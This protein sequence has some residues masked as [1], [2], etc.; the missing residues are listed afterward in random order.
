ME[1]TLID[2]STPEDSA[3]SSELTPS[4]QQQLEDPHHVLGGGADSELVHD[5]HHTLS[6]GVGDSQTLLDLEL[7]DPQ[8]VLQQQQQQ[9]LQQQQQQQQHQSKL[10]KHSDSHLFSGA[11]SGSSSPTTGKEGGGL[12][13]QSGGARS[14]AMMRGMGAT[15]TNQIKKG[16]RSRSPSTGPTPVNE[17]SI[18]FAATTSSAGGGSGGDVDFFASLK[19]G[20]SSSISSASTTPI[21][22]SRSAMPPPL[23]PSPSAVNT[24]F[25]PARTS[26]DPG[27]RR[28]D[29]PTIR[30]SAEYN[31]LWNSPGRRPSAAFVE[32]VS[33]SARSSV[34]GGGLGQ[35]QYQGGS[36][37]SLGFSSSSLSNVTSLNDSPYQPSASATSPGLGSGTFP[38]LNI[39]VSHLNS[40]V[41]QQQPQNSNNFADFSKFTPPPKQVPYGVSPQTATPPLPPPPVLADLDPLYQNLPTRSWTE[42]TMFHDLPPQDAIGDAINRMFPLTEGARPLRRLLRVDEAER[43]YGPDG[44]LTALI[45]SNS[46]RAACV[47]ARDRLVHVL[48]RTPQRV[49]DIMRWW[50]VRLVGLERLR[51][52]DVLA[53]EMERLMGSIAATPNGGSKAWRFEAYPEVFPGRKG[54]MVSFEIRVMW[55][56]LP[57]LRGGV[58]DAISRIY[59]LILEARKVAKELEKVAAEKVNLMDVGFGGGDVGDGFVAR[60][61]IGGGGQ[62]TTGTTSTE[63]LSLWRSRVSQLQLVVARLLLEMKDYRLASAVMEELIKTHPTDVDLLSALGR[64]HLQYGNVVDAHAIF[65]RIEDI[66]LKGQ[67]PRKSAIAIDGKPSVDPFDS[68]LQQ[69]QSTTLMP[70]TQATP[71]SDARIQPFECKRPELVLSNRAF[72]AIAADADWETACR[73]LTE[74]VSINAPSAD[75]SP[76]S[77]MANPGDK[78][79][80]INNLAVCH[81]Y[82][83]NVGQ[84]LSFLETLAVENPSLAGGCPSLLF[85]LATLYDLADQSL[86]RKRRLLGTVVASGAGD[87]LETACLKM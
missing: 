16:L 55:A 87:D 62:V 54:D 78:A 7:T 40:E 35:Q 66:L 50:Y 86:E 18:P 84:A 80:A 61:K 46:W 39:A 58:S 79:G 6:A 13:P 60:L 53:A 27:P 31:D 83:G 64:L 2:T 51:R 3:A 44:A 24:S 82:M 52:W 73:Y 32:P 1:G 34:A 19:D 47:L 8:Q 17:G 20:D 25:S 12:T 28:V 41:Q 30:T 37:G 23:I 63:P 75:S 15:L 76:E 10:F 56:R 85:N 74:L 33:A 5:V 57:A 67:A 36:I 68:V 77:N 43:K 29:S 49:E 45:M 21:L 81:L 72:Y 22:P 59:A 38:S 4:Q 42:P 14:M 11:A 71:S 70:P 9:Q 65:T 26:M 48:S 69:S